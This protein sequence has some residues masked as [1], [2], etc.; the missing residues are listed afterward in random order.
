M[1][2]EKSSKDVSKF[3]E[4]RIPVKDSVGAPS[5]PANATPSSPIIEGMKPLPAPLQP[6]DNT[7]PK[8][9]FRLNSKGKEKAPKSSYL[10]SSEAS[11]SEGAT[12]EEEDPL[13]S[14]PTPKPRSSTRKRR[15]ERDSWFDSNGLEHPAPASILYGN[16]RFIDTETG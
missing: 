3:C 6:S 16:A 12:D 7:I 13:L 11:S 4:V 8:T 5:S 1:E 10:A 14:S 15:M 9:P 2:P